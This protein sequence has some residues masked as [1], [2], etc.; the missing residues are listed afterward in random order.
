MPPRAIGEISD[1]FA[2]AEISDWRLRERLLSLARDLDETP[3]ASLPNAV[4]TTAA[5]EAAYRFLGNSRVTLDGI[6]A[7]HIRATARRCAEAGI[8]YVASDTT[9]CSFSGEE[10]GTRL[11][12]LHG[13]SRGFL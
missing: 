11:G 10:R 13:N 12:R 5:R 6:L 1:E 9:E 2:G 7:P 4:G 8:V 3:G